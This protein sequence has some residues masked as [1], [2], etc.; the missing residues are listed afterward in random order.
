MRNK[1]KLDVPE[2]SVKHGE[3]IMEKEFLKR[4]YFDF[5]E[6]MLGS[7]PKKMKGK[8]VELGSGGGFIKELNNDVI[9]TDIMEIPG[10]DL[11]FAAEKMPFKDS[12]VKAFLGLNVLHHIKDPEKAFGEME[13]CLKKGG[14][15][16]FIEPS[17]TKFSKI[18]Y[19]LFHHE[20]FDENAGWKSNKEGALSD[21]NIALP[22]IIFIRDDAARFK[23][24]YPN[25]K[26]RNVALH[27]PFL[28]VASGG[29]KSMISMPILFYPLIK[30]IDKRMSNL[31]LFMTVTLIKK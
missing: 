4:L 28:Y 10:V 14:I 20:E 22:W 1:S 21:S 15:I 24:L 31:G 9:T 12:S 30:K 25:I 3:I 27:T 18:V 8:I 7:I 5:Y 6:E 17:N 29:L 19:K 2:T 11:K 23:K 26:I 16:C 13:R